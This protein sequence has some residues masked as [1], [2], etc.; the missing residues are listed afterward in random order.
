MNDKTVINGLRWHASDRYRLLIMVGGVG[1][2]GDFS[3]TDQLKKQQL[4]TAKAISCLY[5]KLR[6]DRR[7]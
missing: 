5:I 2:T 7:I 1:G 3:Q 4:T 6:Y